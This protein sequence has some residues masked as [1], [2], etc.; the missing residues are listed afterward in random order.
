M[1]IKPKLDTLKFKLKTSFLK[2]LLP[3]L[4]IQATQIHLRPIVLIQILIT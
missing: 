1:L 4:V 2:T 3:L